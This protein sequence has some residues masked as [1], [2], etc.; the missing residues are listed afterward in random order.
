MRAINEKRNK[1]V[2]VTLSPLSVRSLSTVLKKI[3]LIIVILNIK[4]KLV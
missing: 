1:K 3:A 2:F 4:I